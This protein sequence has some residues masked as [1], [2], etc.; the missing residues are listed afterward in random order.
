MGHGP[1]LIEAYTYR[2]EDHNTIDFS[3]RYRTKEEVDSWL[4]KD[5]ITRFETYLES[6]N[7]LDNNE[8]THIAEDYAKI[9]DQAIE[10][11]E[12]IKKPDIADYFAYMYEEMPPR[13]KSELEEAEQFYTGSE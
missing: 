12:K 11:A 7:I 3:K 1:T 9:V 6:K 8:K 5:P 2:L 4:K 10:T 13:L